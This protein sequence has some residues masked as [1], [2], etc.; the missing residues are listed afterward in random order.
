MKKQIFTLIGLSSSLALF[1]QTP[2]SKV[3][4]SKGQKIVVTTTVS[5]VSSMAPGMEANVTSVNEN[6]LEV[7]NTADKNSTISSTLTKVKLNMEMP[8]NTNSYD[9]EKKE[10][11]NTEIGKGMSERLNKVTDIT[12]DNASG[13]ALTTTKPAP[14]KDIDEAN[15]MQNMMNMFGD[16]GSDE[17][18]VSGA[19]QLIP[20]GKKPGD[21]WSDSTIEKD[22][23]V[24]RTYNFK[25]I[26]DTGS[27]VQLTTVIESTG[28]MEM[29]GMSM[30]VNTT[31]QTTSDILLDIA[32]GLVKR[33]SSEANVTGNFQLMGQAVPV[34]AKATTLSTY[35]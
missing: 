9:S 13:T 11:Q 2:A 22:L 28:T 23:K 31:T 33:K 17:G 18:V 1:A 14:K 12:I 26:A 27:I 16:T 10:D 5:I 3:V 21:S 8:G 35:K 30:D 32:T 6:L 24:R 19:F 20:A 29:M 4:L 7:K 34:S 15:P 25:S